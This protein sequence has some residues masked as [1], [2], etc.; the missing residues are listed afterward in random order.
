MTSP[1]SKH[2][3]GGEQLQSPR[4]CW[5]STRRLPL[6]QAASTRLNAEGACQDVVMVDRKP[7]ALIANQ[8]SEKDNPGM[9]L[10]AFAES[11]ITHQGKG[12]NGGGKQSKRR[13][14]VER[15]G[16]CSR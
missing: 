1:H 14:F 9:T 13:L 2:T 3:R 7:A 11:P 10:K 8:Q 4:A 16:P 15:N 5:P 6:Y 12:P